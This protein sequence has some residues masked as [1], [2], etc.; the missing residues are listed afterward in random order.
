MITNHKFRGTSVQPGPTP[1]TPVDNSKV[2]FYKTSDGKP[3]ETD[4]PNLVSNTY[5]TFGKMVFSEPVTAITP[6]AFA[7]EEIQ[8]FNIPDSVVEVG[9]NSFQDCQYL[10]RVKIGSGVTVIDAAA[11]WSCIRLQSIVIPDNVINILGGAFFD[12]TS[13]SSA[14]IGS[15]VTTIGDEVFNGCLSLSTINYRGTMQQ[16]N[17]ITKGNDWNKYV[18]AEVV[19]CTDGDIYLN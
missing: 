19:H 11:F 7:G 1:P 8:T 4:M 2:I 6:E 9:R 5:T 18:P 17:A 13:L 14:T 12:C 15:G 16:W 10:T 3:I